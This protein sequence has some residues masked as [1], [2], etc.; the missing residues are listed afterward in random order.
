MGKRKLKTGD[1]YLKW[2]E[3]HCHLINLQYEKGNDKQWGICCKNDKIY[4][5]DTLKEAVDEAIECS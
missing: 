2:L 4:Y 3:E 5:G 1:Q